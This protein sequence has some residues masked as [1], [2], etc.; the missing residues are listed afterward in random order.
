MTTPESCT[1]APVLANSFRSSRAELTGRWLDRLVNRLTIP[2]ERIFPTDDLLDHVPLL[3]DG[4]ADYLE[5]P[6]DPLPADTAVMTHARELGALRHA[7]GFSEYEILKEFEIFGGILFAQLARVVTELEEQPVAG[8]LL[9]C[10]HR[11]FQ[12]VAL[13]QQA[14]TTRFLELAKARV[15]EREERLR[16]F[17]R[18]LTHE[19][20]NRIGATL[21]A[22]QLLQLGGLS[23]ERRD[24]LAGVVVRNADSMRLV[25]ENLLEL[26]R[27]EPETRQERHVCL[28]AAAAEVARQLRDAAAAAG[29]ELRVAAGMPEVEVSAAAV[30]FV[31]TNLVANGIKYSDA[32]KA[33]RWVEISAQ[34]RGADGQG[35]E[36]VVTVR[37]NGLGIP[38]GKRSRL[39]ERYY[40][41]HEDQRPS[42]DGTGLGLSLVR[43]TVEALG[44]RV[45]A[46]FP[47]H[48]SLFG[49]TL[50]CRRVTDA[51]PIVDESVKSPT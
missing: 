49:F 42:V 17:H 13:I 6:A 22:G 14:T 18:A 12:A 32:R 30:E 16:A 40:R 35:P 29:V 51:V 8:D 21:G 4:I 31:L 7:Q 41:A 47:E 26:S 1:L 36:L 38:Q 27:L 50:P 46:E 48:G 33:T 24:R 10:A 28:P 23:D 15:I 45:W 34:S 5:D 44:G 20:R 43:D 3:I 19:M 25:L 11:L 2:A 39:F 9:A 37:D